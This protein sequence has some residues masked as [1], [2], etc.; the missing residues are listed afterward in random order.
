M[1]ATG[2]ARLLGALADQVGASARGVRIESTTTNAIRA[3]ILDNTGA[4]VGVGLTTET[5]PAGQS[6]TV[7][8]AWDS[9]AAISGLDFAT[10]RVNGQLVPMTVVPPTAAWN[11]VTSTIMSAGV[12]LGGVSD[13]NG[14][15]LAIH[16]GITQSS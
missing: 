9:G 11:F 6:V 14:R 2:T 10:L 16:A 13:F 4:L 15:V 5:Y 7:R 3:V 1:G 8:L 12:G